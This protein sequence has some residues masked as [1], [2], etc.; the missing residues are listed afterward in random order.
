MATVED[1]SDSIVSSV[2]AGKHKVSRRVLVAAPAAEIFALVADPHRHP[3]LDG[4]GTLR[5]TAVTGP[6]RLSKGDTFSVGMKQYGVPYKI[7]STVTEFED[8]RLIEWRHPLGHRWR[9]ELVETEPGRTQVT[10]TFDSSDA[11]SPILLEIGRVPKK[12]AAGITSTL[13]ALATRFA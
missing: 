5:D 11:K 7:I 1:M 6:D 4:S 3:E 2:A 10:E 12:N 9:W 13:Q 8:G